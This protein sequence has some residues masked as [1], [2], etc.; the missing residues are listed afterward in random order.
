MKKEYQKPEINSTIKVRRPH[1]LSD[2]E[3][4]QGEQ[5]ICTYDDSCPEEEGL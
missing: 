2:S 3:G 1:L 5:P 4:K